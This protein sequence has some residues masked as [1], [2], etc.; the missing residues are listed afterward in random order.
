[1][2][3][4]YLRDTIEEC[5]K[6]ENI[7][8]KRFY[9]YSKFKYDSIIKKFYYT[10]CDYQNFTP[11]EI[12]L[13]HNRMHLRDN[14]KIYSIAGFL[15]SENWIDYISKI[16][17]KINTTQKLYFILDSGW[18]YEG[19]QEEIFAILYKIGWDLGDFFI[20]SKKFDWFI[21]HDNLNDS[22]IMYENK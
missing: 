8:R 22:A 13:K 7:N 18:L 5:I 11:S 15:Q 1:M 4:K 19:Y 21:V 6:E 2:K 10:F 14:L 12:L 17:L 3:L 9:E 20:L 16:K